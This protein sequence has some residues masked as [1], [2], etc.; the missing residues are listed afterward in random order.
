[1]GEYGRFPGINL[2]HITQPKPF[3]LPGQQ[4]IIRLHILRRQAHQRPVAYFAALARAVHKL[5]V[6][7]KKT[8]VF[9]QVVCHF[10][11]QAGTVGLAG[12]MLHGR[13]ADNQVELSKFIQKAGTG[14]VGLL[15]CALWQQL[16]CMGKQTCAVVYA[17]VGNRMAVFVQELPETAVAAPHIQHV[18]AGLGQP[19]QQQG[20]TRLRPFPTVGKRIGNLLIKLLV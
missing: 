19:R 4:I 8:A 3:S 17:R 9:R 6:C 5:P 13:Q 16:A 1:M 20:K 14:H 10:G 18:L 2:A 12:N 11:Q 15:E 7:Q